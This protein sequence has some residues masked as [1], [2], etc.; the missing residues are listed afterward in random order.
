LLKIV[1]YAV[2]NSLSFYQ[3]IKPEWKEE[4]KELKM[5]GFVQK[6]VLENG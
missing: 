5:N 4:V 6:N 3:I 2:K 1:L